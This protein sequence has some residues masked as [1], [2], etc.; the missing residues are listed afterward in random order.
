VLRR[1]WLAMGSGSATRRWPA[2][3]FKSDVQ[4]AGVWHRRNTVRTLLL[5][6]KAGLQGVA[7]NINELKN[8]DEAVRRS[9][10]MDAL[11]QL[12]GGIAHDFNNVL[13]IILGNAEIVGT[14]AKNIE[15]TKQPIA[16]IVK[17]IEHAA[18]LTKR[19]LAF[20]RP[21][22]LEPQPCEIDQ[23]ISNI[24]EMLRRTLGANITLSFSL[25]CDGA[26]ASTNLQC[27]TSR[28]NLPLH[29]PYYR[30]PRWIKV[31]HVKNDFSVN[32]TA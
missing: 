16:E 28:L 31:R 10:K 19:L 12:S 15:A 13:S 11:G 20:S 22:R 24:E 5:K 17:S 7:R 1:H 8:S 30:I 3:Y 21:D 14:N 2:V 29:L 23:V 18:S 4:H 6:E 25:G 26:L 9:Q 32:K 27:A